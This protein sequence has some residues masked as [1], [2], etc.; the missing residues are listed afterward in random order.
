MNT[1]Y[2]MCV[3]VV[4]VLVFPQVKRLIDEEVHSAQRKNETIMQGLM[5]TIEKQVHGID[6]ERSIQTLE[7]GGSDGVPFHVL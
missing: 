3:H 6:F 1:L 5:E 4:H 2:S 7:V